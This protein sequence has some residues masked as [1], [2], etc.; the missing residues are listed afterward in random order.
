MISEIVCRWGVTLNVASYGEGRIKST[1]IFCSGRDVR[2]FR[3]N[4]W[5]SN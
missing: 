1:D 2:E 3:T 5:T 4:S